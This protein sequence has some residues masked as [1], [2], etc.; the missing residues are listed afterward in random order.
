MNDMDIYGDCQ[1]QVGLP[2]S[3]H[4]QEISIKIQHFQ[5]P[6]PRSQVRKK[7][8]KKNTKA[9]AL[10]QKDVKRIEESQTS[11]HISFISI[12]EL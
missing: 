9:R 4:F 2:R 11:N 3:R 1:N 12:Q 7:V 8:V 5:I 10:G 6:F